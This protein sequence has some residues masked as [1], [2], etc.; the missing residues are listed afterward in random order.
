[1]VKHTKTNRR[2]LSTNCLS[3]FDHFVGLALKRLKFIP[4]WEYQNKRITLFFYKS[5]FKRTL[6][7][8]SKNKMKFEIGS[9][10][11][12]AFHP[13]EFGQI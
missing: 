1:M 5:N 10:V 4:L 11:D 12:A 8:S 9:K 6:E 3:V 2:L 13:S 7:N